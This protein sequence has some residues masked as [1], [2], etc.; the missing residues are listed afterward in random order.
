MSSSHHSISDRWRIRADAD[1]TWRF[2]DGEYVVHHALSND[3]FRLSEDAGRLLVRLARGDSQT[4]QTLAE[5]C[6]M[7]GSDPRAT[8]EELARLGFVARC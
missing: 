3:T 1:L 2:W 6:E 4:S 8:L 5:A 7:S